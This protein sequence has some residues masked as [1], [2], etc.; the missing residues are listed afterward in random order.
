MAIATFT[1]YQSFWRHPLLPLTRFIWLIF[2][3][4]SLL[5]AWSVL[6]IFSITWHL[7][8][9][10]WLFGQILTHLPIW[11][12]LFRIH[13]LIT[14]LHLFNFE[15][16]DFLELNYIFLY[17]FLVL[18]DNNLLRLNRFVI[19]TVAVKLARRIAGSGLCTFY[20]TKW[21]WSDTSNNLFSCLGAH[22]SSHYLWEIVNCGV[23]W[24]I[25]AVWVESVARVYSLFVHFASY[26]SITAKNQGWIVNEMADV[27]RVDN[28]RSKQGTH[29]VLLEFLIETWG[30]AN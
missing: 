4:F 9:Q 22:A 16:L 1:H 14:A 12:V 17:L 15:W 19:W 6:L 21:S 30:A 23:V 25:W 11:Q 3:I 5:N 27:W 26:D 29:T 8:S 20:A 2:I 13:I 10:L 18:D 28:R 24:S 7:G